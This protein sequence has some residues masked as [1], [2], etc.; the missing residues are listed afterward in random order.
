MSTEQTINYKVILEIIISRIEREWGVFILKLSN[1]L[2]T[3]IFK[4]HTTHVLYTCRTL[5]LEGL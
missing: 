1:I 4:R 5:E 2:S 3:H